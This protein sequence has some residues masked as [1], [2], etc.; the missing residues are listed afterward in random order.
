MLM[1][2]LKFIFA[3]SILAQLP[4]TT[5]GQTTS[6]LSPQ[7]M[8]A[9][10]GGIVAGLF[11]VIGWIVTRYRE[12]ATRRREATLRHLQRQIEEL[13]GPLY[14]LL[15]QSKVTYDVAKKVLPLR[16]NGRLAI[17]R[18][19]PKQQELWEHFV[20]HYLRPLN[21]QMSEIIR[22]KMYL[23]EGGVMPESFSNYL[24]HAAQSEAVHAL[25]TPE[26]IKLVDV[27]V[28]FPTGF[29]DDVE[30]TL[31]ELVH[32]YSTGIKDTSLEKH[33]SVALASTHASRWRRWFKRNPPKTSSS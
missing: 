11:T 10:A 7:L 8:G 2:T 19:E 29:P 16:T 31:Y 33:R 21:S 30:K 23:L 6:V 5:D 27:W 20:D 18:F 4:L 9:I 22:T 3:D 15:R 14:G 28:A 32:R 26:A 1:F 24:E 12:D 17:E 13:Y 25:R